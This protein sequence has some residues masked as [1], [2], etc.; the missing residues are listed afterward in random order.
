[1]NQLPFISSLTSLR[2]IAAFVVV[3]F[4]VDAIWLKLFSP[5]QRFFLHKGY[6]LVDFFFLLSGFIMVHV[7]G[8]DFESFQWTTFKRF[9]QA[10]FARIYPVHFFALIGLIIFY[11]LK[12]SHLPGNPFDGRVWD[13]QALPAHFLLVQGMGF[14]SFFSWNVPS[15]SIS[16]EW[17]MYMLFPLLMPW[18]GKLNFWKQLLGFLVVAVLYLICYY[19]L[20]PISESLSPFPG[21][22][23]NSLD[24]IYDF[25]FIRCFAG[26]TGGMLLHRLYRMNWWAEGWKSVFAVPC[27]F[28]LIGLSMQL[29]VPDYLL[30]PEF[31][32]LLLASAHCT[33]TTLEWLTSKPLMFMG[34]ISYSVYMIHMPLLIVRL[35][36]FPVLPVWL[37]GRPN[38]FLFAGLFVVVVLVVSS[39]TYFT[40][41]LPLRKRLGPSKR[42]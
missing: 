5:D 24:L 42:I 6:L 30:I 19:V 27:L 41:E 18:F 1:M 13:P 3:L 21:G 15:W 10:R 39:F 31:G 36:A 22:R 8:K 4:H 20:Y 9:V 17:W 32:A 16:T 40:V 37:E 11:V 26:F 14:L 35:Y 29:E 38:D 28:L 34:E 25:A 12:V 7:Y 2:G 23:G 33:G